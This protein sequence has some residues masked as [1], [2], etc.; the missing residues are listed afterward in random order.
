MEP[1]PLLAFVYGFG[2]SLIVEILLI[3]RDGATWRPSGEVQD[4]A[5]LGS[6]SRARAPLRGNRDRVLHS[7]NPSLPVRPHGCRNS[8]NNYTGVSRWRG[9]IGVRRERSPAAPSSG[10]RPQIAW[11]VRNTP[12]LSCFLSSSGEPCAC[13]NSPSCKCAITNG[14][15]RISKPKMRSFAAFFSLPP[16]RPSRLAHLRV[17]FL[18]RRLVEVSNCLDDIRRLEP[19]QARRMVIRSGP[20]IT[21]TL[22]ENSVARR[23][24]RQFPHPHARSFRSAPGSI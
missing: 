2:G 15:G 23:R 7:P 5:I 18:Q 1:T 24:L 16:S 10:N 21:L 12:A 4:K 8:G 6:S 3:L 20:W 9:R 11:L 22:T 17:E 19:M 13:R 14:A